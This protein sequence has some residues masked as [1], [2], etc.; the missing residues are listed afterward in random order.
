MQFLFMKL[1]ERRLPQQTCPHVAFGF[2][3]VEVTLALGIVG[4]AFLALFGM[5]PIGL[6]TFEGAV[7][8]TVESQ[9]AQSVITTAHQ[10][11]FSELP[12]MHGQQQYFD[13]QGKSGQNIGAANYVYRTRVT[14]SSQ[15]SI[16]VSNP[17]HKLATVL[18]A[19]EKISG[20][21]QQRNFS[22]LIADNGL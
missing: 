15:T 3:L 4:F 14:V 16:P 9:I 19:I 1:F 8:S 10:S 12:S 18:V 11:K 13:E 7:D 5:L 2:S 6:K 22:A 20:P 17:N 21:N